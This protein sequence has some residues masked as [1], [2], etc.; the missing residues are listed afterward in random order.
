MFIE[1]TM[2]EYFVKRPLKR[3]KRN[4]YDLST[5]NYANGFQAADMAAG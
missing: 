1:V 3:A 4:H 5:Q 2:V